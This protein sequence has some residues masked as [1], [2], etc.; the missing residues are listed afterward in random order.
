MFQILAIKYSKGDR[1][2]DMV[3]KTMRERARCITLLKDKYPGLPYYDV[4]SLS[5]LE[6]I[7]GVMKNNSSEMM[8]HERPRYSQEERMR[9]RRWERVF[10]ANSYLSSVL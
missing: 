6:I 10:E 1:S 9:A 7:S 8:S 4:D 3:V 5:V 2:M